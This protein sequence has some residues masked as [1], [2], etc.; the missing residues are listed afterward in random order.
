MAEQREP[1]AERERGRHEDRGR[2]AEPGRDR[3]RRGIPEAEEPKPG[4][5]D[6]A[7]GRQPG[8]PD[9]FPTFSHRED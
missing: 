8:K 5:D 6:P 2:D 3:T 7:K 4:A 1:D 9:L